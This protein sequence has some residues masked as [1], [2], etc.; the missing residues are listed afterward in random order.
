MAFLTWASEPTHTL[1]YQPT[2]AVDGELGGSNLWTFFFL[3]RLLLCN[4]PFWRDWLKT[5]T[6]LDQHTVNRE[7]WRARVFAFWV[8]SRSSGRVNQHLHMKTVQ[9][10]ACLLF[11]R[12][13]V[14]ERFFLR[15]LL[16]VDG[17]PQLT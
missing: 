4:W 3:E 11:P 10:R 5:T 9:N 14:L 16:D 6:L 13:G 1:R 15:G 2:A 17:S 7:D 8:F 12:A